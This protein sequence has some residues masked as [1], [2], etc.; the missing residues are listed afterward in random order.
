MVF[1]LSTSITIILQRKITNN[2]IILTTTSNYAG[3]YLT[4]ARVH[5][6]HNSILMNGTSG[7]RCVYLDP[8]DATT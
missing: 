8:I 4:Y 2:D 6:L 3:I 1:M 7:D 5:V